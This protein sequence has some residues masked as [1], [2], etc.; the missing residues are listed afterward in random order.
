[1]RV[2]GRPRAGAILALAPATRY[3]AFAGAAM[4]DTAEAIARAN[5][6]LLEPATGRPTTWGHFDPATLD[7]D[8]DWADERGL[9]ALEI[10]AWLRQG[11]AAGAPSL[12]L[13]A[14]GLEAAGYGAQARNAYITAPDDVNFSDDELFVFPVFGHLVYAGA[15]RRDPGLLCGY[16][17]G[18]A[19]SLAAERGALWAAMHY[20][21]LTD[22]VLPDADASALYASCAAAADPFGAAP[23]LKEML[24]SDAADVSWSLQN[25]PLDPVH[26]CVGY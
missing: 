7:G 24:K 18:W 22:V 4:R 11:E 3:A 5:F 12:G 9:N 21:V 20:A 14:D 19:E 1:M 25:W 15:W 13:A 17:R 23:D 6:T 26:R 8:R 10:L 2:G 16:A